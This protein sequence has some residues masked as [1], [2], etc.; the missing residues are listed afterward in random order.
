MYYTVVLLAVP[1][2]Q[3]CPKLHCCSMPDAISHKKKNQSHD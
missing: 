3:A 1:F 2:S